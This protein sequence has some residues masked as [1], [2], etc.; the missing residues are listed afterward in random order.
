[1]LK[2]GANLEIIEYCEGSNFRTDTLIYKKRYIFET[3]M[4]Q[5]I[6]FWHQVS[7]KMSIHIMFDPIFSFLESLKNKF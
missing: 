7:L 2:A 4:S 5:R 1:M 6:L 3:E